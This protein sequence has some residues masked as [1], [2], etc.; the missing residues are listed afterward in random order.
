MVD[1]ALHERCL[2]LSSLS[3]GIAIQRQRWIE[4]A[5]LKVTEFDTRC[6]SERV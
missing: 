5:S 2:L 3:R 6:E 1:R 4:R